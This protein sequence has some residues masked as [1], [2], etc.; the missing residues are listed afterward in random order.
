V[1]I[2]SQA[3]SAAYAANVA[4]YGI[5]P[6]EAMPAA[7]EIMFCSATPTSKKRSGWRMPKSMVRLAYARSAVSTTM[8]SSAS[9]RSASSAP[10]TN[11]GTEVSAIPL[12]DFGSLST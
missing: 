7:I 1:R 10:A 11:A 6:V 9:A 3:S 5:R 12:P 8:R 4:A 2:C